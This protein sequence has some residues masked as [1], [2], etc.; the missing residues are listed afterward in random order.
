MFLSKCSNECNYLKRFGENLQLLGLNIM[1]LWTICVFLSASPSL[2][3]STG[4]PRS[5]LPL[6]RLWSVLLG[7]EVPDVQPAS[8]GKGELRAALCQQGEEEGSRLSCVCFSVYCQHTKW[9]QMTLYMHVC[10]IQNL[11]SCSVSPHVFKLHKMWLETRCCDPV[12]AGETGPVVEDGGRREGG[13]QPGN[14]L[15]N[16]AQHFNISSPPLPLLA[17]GLVKWNRRRWSWG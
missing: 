13:R 8:T 14:K 1:L 15:W 3:F 9:P 5:V 7:C 2:C 16:L 11:I 10:I 17:L 12:L 6:P 4:R